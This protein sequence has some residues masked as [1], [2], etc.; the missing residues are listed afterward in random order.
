VNVTALANLSESTIYDIPRLITSSCV[1]PFAPFDCIA[2]C[3]NND[4][5]VF[6][7]RVL[8]LA[9]VPHLGAHT[10]MSER[11]LRVPDLAGQIT[12]L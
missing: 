9:H 11:A 4:T 5:L 1:V 3:S 7:R 12:P 6:M 8:T 2:I 10:K